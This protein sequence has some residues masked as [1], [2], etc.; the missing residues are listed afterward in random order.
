MSEDE[1]I[2]LIKLVFGNEVYFFPLKLRDSGLDMK[3]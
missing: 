2:S 3:L 1:F